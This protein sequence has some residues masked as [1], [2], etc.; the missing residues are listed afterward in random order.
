MV[1][2]LTLP[3]YPVIKMN[4][5]LDIPFGYYMLPTGNSFIFIVHDKGFSPI[6][7]LLYIFSH[8]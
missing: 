1:F 6:T 5:E 4:Y 7:V 2:Q 8:T 3:K